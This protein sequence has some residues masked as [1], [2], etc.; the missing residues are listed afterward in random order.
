M[1]SES[2]GIGEFTSFSQ[3]PKADAPILVTDDGSMTDL[4]EWHPQN[5]PGGI[6]GNFEPAQKETVSSDWHASK[7]EAPRK[8]TDDGM[9]IVVMLRQE[10]KAS[11]PID[12]RR[13]FGPIVT[14][15]I[16]SH[17]RKQ[18]SS[19]FSISSAILTSESV[20]KYRTRQRSFDDTMKSPDRWKC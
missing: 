3:S 2:S 4:S 13:E 19:I 9:R 16:V 6:T 1:S 10:S 12:D 18:P 5:A 20:P 8:V 11:T 7:Q 15:T 14:L 17:R